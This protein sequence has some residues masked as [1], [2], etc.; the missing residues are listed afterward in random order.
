VAAQ[1]TKQGANCRRNSSVDNFI[2]NQ[3][4]LI[5]EVISPNGREGNVMTMLKNLHTKWRTWTQRKVQKQQYGEYRQI[6]EQKSLLKRGMML[7]SL[8][9]IMEIQKNTNQHVMQG[10]N[11]LMTLYWR[12]LTMEISN[13]RIQDK[14]TIF[15]LHCHVLQVEEVVRENIH[16]IAVRR[17]LDRKQQF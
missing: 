8:L 9:V 14:S 12:K 15:R 2:Q 11:K 7:G 17:M 13:G 10:R 4:A 1:Q 6:L 3:Q 16:E 5:N